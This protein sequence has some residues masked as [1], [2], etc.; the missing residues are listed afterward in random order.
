[1]PEPGL[2]VA[3]DDTGVVPYPSWSV[4]GR[5]EGPEWFLM[6]TGARNQSGWSSCTPGSA[7]PA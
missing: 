2:Y 6:T 7:A 1:L 5:N 4:C 3:E